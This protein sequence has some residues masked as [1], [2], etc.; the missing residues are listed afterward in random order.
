MNRTDVSHHNRLSRARRAGA[1]LRH[2]LL[3]G[4][5]AAQAGCWT[6]GPV[7]EE[8]EEEFEIL[9]G[10]T[11]PG[12]GAI[13]TDYDFGV[14]VAV[15][16]STELGPFDVYTGTDPGFVSLE[17]DEG[18]LYGLPDGLPV[19]VE[20]TAIDEGVQILFGESVLAQ[21]GDSAVIGTT[22]VHLHPQ[23][24]LVLAAGVEPAPRFVS[25]T[26]SAGTGEYAVSEP[27]TATLEVVD[28]HQD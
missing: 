5:L 15:E 14:P 4:A 19:V 7:P 8:E 28:D 27:Y 12:G 24:Q 11:E 22:P 26:V 13:A 10:S 1:L 25:F 3:A 16:F 18:D 21:V 9:I 6:D 23:W 2:V 20:I 17:D